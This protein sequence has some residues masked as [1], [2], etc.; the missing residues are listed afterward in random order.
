MAFDARFR[1][2]PVSHTSTLRRQRPSIS[3]ALSPAG[4]PPM[5]SVSYR[6]AARGGV[7]RE[8]CLALFVLHGLLEAS[9]VVRDLL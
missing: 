8:G 5:T 6:S 9:E 7:A 1:C 4:P 2:R 3:A